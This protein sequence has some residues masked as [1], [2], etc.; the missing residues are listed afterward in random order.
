MSFNRRIV[1]LDCEGTAYDRE[2]FEVIIKTVDETSIGKGTDRGVIDSSRIQ[3]ADNLAKNDRN[4]TNSTEELQGKEEKADSIHVDQ[5]EFVDDIAE[6]EDDSVFFKVIG[7]R[8]HT[9]D[10]VYRRT[11]EKDRT[12]A[13]FGSSKNRKP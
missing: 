13:P 11:H 4:D 3:N 12:L 1:Y 2:L 9:E 10:S 5:N 8:G 7:D 6:I